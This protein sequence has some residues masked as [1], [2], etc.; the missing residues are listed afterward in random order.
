MQPISIVEDTGLQ[1]FV[2]AL[3]SR[4]QPPSRMTV[5]GTLLPNKYQEIVKKLHVD[6]DLAENVA[7]RTDI[8]TSVQT[9]GYITLTAHYI[10]PDWEL[11]SPVLATVHLLNEHTADNIASELEKVTNK[12]RI[13][14]KTVCVVTNN[15]A[16]MIAAAHISA[17]RHLPCF[18][19]TLN[20]AVTDAIKAQNGLLLV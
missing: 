9:K 17:W 14:D 2:Y 10:T 11:K 15:A 6:L 19:H 4:Y 20:L 1:K 13:K 12:W 18:A 8:W 16:N 5:T 7:T 3:E